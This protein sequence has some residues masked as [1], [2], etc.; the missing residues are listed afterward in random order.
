MDEQRCYA[1]QISQNLS[2]PSTQRKEHPSSDASNKSPR[3]SPSLNR[4]KPDQHQQ[5][6]RHAAQY[7]AYSFAN[8]STFL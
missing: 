7:T 3:R 6:R 1:P 8:T 2:T 4:A 5:V